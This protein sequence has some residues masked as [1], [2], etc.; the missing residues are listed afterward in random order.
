MADV[1]VLYFCISVFLLIEETDLNWWQGWVVEARL[2][3]LEFCCISLVADLF[4]LYFCIFVFLLI[5]RVE[6]C[7]DRRD[8]RSCKICANCVIFP[9]E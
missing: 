8:R 2:F 3:V 5:D 6:I 4:V 7:R 9:G 1:F